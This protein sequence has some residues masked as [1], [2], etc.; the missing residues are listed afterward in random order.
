MTVLLRHY[1]AAIEMPLLFFMKIPCIIC[2]HAAV[3][4]PPPYYAAD[5]AYAAAEFCYFGSCRHL[6]SPLIFADAAA[7]FE[8]LPPCHARLCRGAGLAALR[9]AFPAMLCAPL[10]QAP[11]MLS[12]YI[13]YA[14]MMALRPYMRQKMRRRYDM[15]LTIFAMRDAPTALL[16][17]IFRF[18]LLSAMTLFRRRR[19]ICHAAARPS[20]CAVY[21][22]DV[23]TRA[24][25]AIAYDTPFHVAGF[26][27]RD[28]IIS[29]R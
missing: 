8:M 3:I 13:C 2:C 10:C 15:L 29:P 14:M 22:F 5:T 7:T 27:A 26:S 18:C 28:V 12:C 17:L 20:V 6:F 23:I 21:L 16:L 9:Y 11:D 24:S 4:T 1:L 25:Y 19:L